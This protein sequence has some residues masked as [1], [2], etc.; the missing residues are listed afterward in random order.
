MEL[1]ELLLLIVN[2]YSINKN[3]VFQRHRSITDLLAS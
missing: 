3:T 1:I 2:Y